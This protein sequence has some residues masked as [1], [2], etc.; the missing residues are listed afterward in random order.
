[1]LAGAIAGLMAQGLE[2]VMRPALAFTCM[3]LRA[4]FCVRSMEWRA[5]YPATFRYYWH[6]PSTLAKLTIR[7]VHIAP[8]LY[9]SKSAKCTR[10]PACRWQASRG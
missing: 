2:P 1:M 3:D 9:S 8:C 10:K 7:K 6:V 5:E 4:N